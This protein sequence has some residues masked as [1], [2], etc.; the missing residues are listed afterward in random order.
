MMRKNVQNRLL[1]EVY[2]Q[3]A[4]E[5]IIEKKKDIQHRK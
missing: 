3:G 1:A 5:L 4:P 2:R